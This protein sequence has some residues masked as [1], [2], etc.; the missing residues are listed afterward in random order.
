MNEQLI[1]EQHQHITSLV[2]GKRLKEGLAQLEAFLYH[3]TDWALHARFEQVQTSYHFMLQYTLQGATDTER[4]KLHF[5]LLADTLEIADQARILLLDSVSTT[6][7]HTCRAHRTPHFKEHII[8][9][10]IQILESFEDDLAVSSLLSNSNIDAVLARH[11]DAQ[12]CIYLYVWMHHVWDTT[13]EAQAQVA[14]QSE[15]LTANDLCLFTSAVTMSM[16]EC[17]D[18]RK[19][20]WLMDAYQH[21]SVEVSQRALV[22]LLIAFHIHSNRLEWYPSIAARIE[23]LNQDVAFSQNI[24]TIYKQLLLTH[25]TEKIDKKIR[26]E[27]IP[28]VIKNMPSIRNMKFGFEENDE[29]KDDHN[30]DWEDAF[31]NTGLEDKLREM[32]ELQ[33]EGA[34]IYMSTFSALKGYPFFKEPHNWFYP[35]D[36]NHSSI[37]KEFR[38]NAQNEHILELILLAGFFCNSDKYSLLFTIFHLPQSQRENMLSEI[39]GQ[40]MS[41]LADQSNT[42]TL[43]KH[44]Q[45]S[46]TISGQYIHDLYRFFKLTPRKGELRDIFKES[47]CLHRLPALAPIVSADL[48]Y[49]LADYHLRKE[50]WAEA[51]AVYKE[52]EALSRDREEAVLYQKIGYSLQKEKKYEE[53]ITMYLRAEIIKAD[54]KWTN[55]HLAACYRITKQFEKA[56]EYYKRVEAVTPND[57]PLIFRIASCLAELKSYEE[58]LNY[59]FKLD[60]LEANST[61]AWR[62]IGWCSFVT[63]K[64]LQANKYYTQLMEMGALAVDYLN[65]GH[66]AWA[67]KDIEKSVALYT[68]AIELS[69]N[70]T[71]FVEMFNKDKRYLIEQGIDQ[72]DMPLMLDLLL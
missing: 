7:Y 42:N 9:S 64:Y 24:T 61:K 15:L 39:A 60:F 69:G 65:A 19:I 67:L 28:E 14:L 34:D 8:G 21:H 54:N 20:N 53:A 59:F 45:L 33:I 44:S 6:Y 13:D 70:K 50:Y 5:K 51:T 55:A 47:I 30:P 12:R 52:I 25:E 1:N 56:L 68:K 2:E 3:C 26:E 4:K 66:V 43:K 48:L 18:L 36:K 40:Q 10:Q 41:D 27:I 58:A 72:E 37:I 38:N 22:G 31:K 49:N 62:G 17:F 29:E 46:S 35:F 57:H 23:L 16:M 32:N 63:G 11:E 71:Y